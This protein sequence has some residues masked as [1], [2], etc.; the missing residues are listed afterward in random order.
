MAPLKPPIVCHSAAQRRNL[1][2]LLL[3]FV[4]TEARTTL[5][6]VILER[7]EGPLYWLLPLLLFVLTEARTPLHS[8]SLSAAKDHC[9]GFCH[10]CC[11]FLQSSHTL[12]LVI[13]E[14]SEGPLYWLLPL[15]LFVLTEARTPL[16]SSSLSAAK[17][18]CI[19]FCRCRCLFYRIGKGHQSTP[20]SLLPTPYSL[21][22]TPCILIKHHER[23]LHRR[24]RQL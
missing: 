18:H 12:T 9:I 2:L 23:L 8:S 5:T 22:P 21:L 19:G 6:L 13:L 1:Q 14:R 4:L 17:D 3:L 11:L 15:L 24:R 7:S 20:Y 16:H 10:C